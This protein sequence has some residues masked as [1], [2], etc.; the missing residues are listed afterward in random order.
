M[1]D[2]HNVCV[3]GFEAASG[4]WPAAV[5]AVP[6]RKVEPLGRCRA[7]EEP[8]AASALRVLRLWRRWLLWRLCGWY[9]R[10][11][12]TTAAGGGTAAC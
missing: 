11:G 8:Y 5:H 10:R 7:G 1:H 6:G 2:P 3:P 4:S 12:G 9:R